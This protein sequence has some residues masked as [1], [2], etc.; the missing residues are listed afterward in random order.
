MFWK[1]KSEVVVAIDIGTHKIAVGVAELM[2]NGSMSLIDVGQAES[3]GVRKGE[4]VQL[5]LA[6]QQIHQAIADAEAK[7]DAV[8]RDV[9]LAFTGSHLLSRTVHVTTPV[10]DENNRVTHDDLEALEKKLRNLPDPPGY[11]TI[12]ELLQRY[13]LDG[14]A[15]TED[16]VGLLSKNIEARYHLICGMETRL[17]STARAVMEHDVKLFGWAS[18]GYASA[19]AVITQDDK[20]LGCVVIDM[21][22]GVTDYIVYVDGAVV[23]SGVLGVGGDHVTQDLSIGLKIPYRIAENLKKNQGLLYAD[24]AEDDV[25][26]LEADASFPETRISRQAVTTI[27][28]L[29]TEETLR[30]VYE[31]IAEKNLWPHIA[32][33]VYLTGGGCQMR[34][35]KRLASSVFA[36]AACEIAS[37]FKF[38]GDQRY[39]NRPDLATLLGLLRY[40]RKMEMQVERPGIFGK[41][42]DAV[43]SLLSEVRFFSW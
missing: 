20:T 39:S 31:D 23:H 6:K 38:E 29:R 34:Q 5:E 32:G 8:I 2:P 1:E 28:R 18:A 22:A 14:D 11:V 17:E 12:H 4:I 10:E 26:V 30:L 27:M 16:P 7:T 33:R 40:A 9:Y 37:Q 42:R 43:G 24:P 15:V 21:G 19:Q 35:L 25:L 13:Y 36:P 3:K 41:M